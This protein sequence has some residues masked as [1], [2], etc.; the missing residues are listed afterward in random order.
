MNHTP[1]RGIAALLHQA[2]SAP[3]NDLDKNKFKINL[4]ALKAGS[5]TF[6]LVERFKF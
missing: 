1:Y 3:V 6:T 5:K 2:Q 4:S